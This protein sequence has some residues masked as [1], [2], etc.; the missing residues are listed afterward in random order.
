MLTQI[1]PGLCTALVPNGVDIEYFR[2]DQQEEQPA[3]IYTGGMNMFANRDAVMY[4]IAQ[5][6]PQ[7]RRLVPD[8]RFYAVGQDP[9]KELLAL[10]D[11]DKQ[12]IVTGYVN[13][14]RPLVREAAVYVVPL[15]VGGGTRLKVLDAMA[16]GKAMVTTSIG[17]EGLEVCPDE[18]VVVADHPD[19]FAERTVHLLGNRLRRLELGRAARELVER[20]YS[21]AHVGGQLL[22]AYHVALKRRGTRL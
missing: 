2:P 3:L 15:R 14:I 8:V 12:I 19:Q 20:R 13:D 17:C 4:F 5:I 6:W 9:P 11:Q 16:M 22:D 1:V 7:I 18:H 21:W 10:A